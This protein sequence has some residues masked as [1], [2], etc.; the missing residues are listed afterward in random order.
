VTV[1]AA[2]LGCLGAAGCLAGCGAHR[3]VGN[4]IPGRT[5]TVYVS[6]PFNGASSISGRS[7]LGGAELALDSVHR[8][9]GRYRIV[10]KALDDSTVKRGGWDPGQTTVDAHAAIANRTTIGYIGEY[11]SGASAVSIP[12]LNRAGIPQISPSSTAV[13]LT[14]GGPAADPGEPQKYYPTQRRTFARVVPND[15]VQAAVQVDLQREAGCRRTYVL[16]DG[17]VDGRDAA[18]SF[19]IAAGSAR[20]RIAGDT[21]FDPAATD[22][23]SLATAVAQTGAD[24]VLISALT[25]NHAA[26][27]T[28][29][30]ADSLPDAR[31]FGDAGLAE[32]TYTDPQLG[33]IPLSL[34]SRILLTVATLGARDY[35]PAGRRFLALYAQ[36]YGPP[37]PY[38][39]YGYAATSLLL[40]AISR[41]TRRG[42]VEATRSNVL[43]SILSTHNQASVLGTYSID[44]SGDTS[45]RRYGVYHVQ[46]GRLVFWKAMSA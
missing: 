10:L 5:L 39:I 44:S 35:P 34:D 40:D 8:H 12:L 1:L 41:A 2:V 20:L 11:N 30:I 26:R 19:V 24:C 45:Q 38:A 13:G 27:L 14:T 17:E 22:Y 46:D 42:T 33:G 28:E 15:T 18:M 9:I 23:R 43:A 7:V 6:L 21:Q 3:Q 32:T 37:Q 25:E 16:N 29:Q 31:L 4:R 36:R